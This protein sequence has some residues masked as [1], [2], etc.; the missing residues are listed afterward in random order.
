MKTLTQTI[1]LTSILFA[2]SAIA[3]TQGLA[4]PMH[5]TE[6]SM[7]SP[8]TIMADKHVH[9]GLYENVLSKSSTEGQLGQGSRSTP[10]LADFCP[11]S[12][13]SVVLNEWSVEKH[14]GGKQ[15]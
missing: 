9:A 10:H 11:V 12:D 14:L 8:S 1:A 7:H 15:C 4:P 3:S 6:F 2:T 13:L 5:S